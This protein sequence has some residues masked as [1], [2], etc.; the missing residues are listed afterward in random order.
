MGARPDNTIVM[1]PAYNEVKTIGGIVKVLVDMGLNVLVIDDG[2]VDNTER[3]ALDAG[4]MVLRHTSNLGKGVSVRS[5]IAH[6]MDKMKYEWIV[7]MDGDGQ[8][9]PED[10][11]SLM[12]VTEKEETD[13]VIGNRMGKTSDMPLDRY[14]TNRFTSWVIS[15]MCG[16]DIPDSQCGFRLLRAGAMRDIVLE[17]DRYDIES[18]MIIHAAGK[19][20]KILSVPVQTI[21]GDELSKINPLRDTIR[22]F[23]LVIKHS[24]AKNG[25]HIKKRSDG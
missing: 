22:F 7:M 20:M 4:A 14:W 2:S 3:E 15:K 21:Y 13:I 17:S 11:T 16:H 1:I 23:R 5:G 25:L 24:L 12:A 8:H 9:H 10:V 19:K 6:V 18:E